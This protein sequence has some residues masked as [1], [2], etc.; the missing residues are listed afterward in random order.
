MAIERSPTYSDDVGICCNIV[1]WAVVLMDEE[2]EVVEDPGTAGHDC[3][4]VLR[5]A[6]TR[7]SKR[8]RR[9]DR[10]KAK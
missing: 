4:D 6:K 7:R 9:D 3:D 10:M 2:A 8:E 5:T 1:R